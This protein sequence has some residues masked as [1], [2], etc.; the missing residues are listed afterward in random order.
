MER[1]AEFEPYYRTLVRN[2]L[3][4]VDFLIDDHKDLIT[5]RLGRCFKD[6]PQI[7]SCLHF[8]ASFTD[9]VCSNMEEVAAEIGNSIEFL[10]LNVD[11]DTFLTVATL[12][13]L[14]DY[15]DENWEDFR[16]ISAKIREQ[17]SLV[18]YTIDPEAIKKLGVD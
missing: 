5:W 7:K 1:E 17:F 15:G 9:T 4:M 13:Y 8:V 18:H 12:C 11:P 16:E 14:L 6:K 3:K 10:R 2:K